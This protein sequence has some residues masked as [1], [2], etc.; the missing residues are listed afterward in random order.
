VVDRTLLTF[1]LLELSS[2]CK[3]KPYK[4]HFDVLKPLLLRWNGRHKNCLLTHLFAEYICSLQ[5]LKWKTPREMAPVVPLVLDIF[6]CRI[7]VCLFKTSRPESWNRNT[8]LL[9]NVGG[10]PWNGKSN[11]YCENEILWVHIK[12][13]VLTNS[14]WAYV[15]RKTKNYSKKIKKKLSLVHNCLCKSKPVNEN[16]PTHH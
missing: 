7:Y 3:L 15:Y 12:R 9:S 5:S 13:C 14:L 10:S 11:G 4:N 8:V 16:S 1:S 2:S 6:R